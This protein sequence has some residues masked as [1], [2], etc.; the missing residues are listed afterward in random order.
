[1]SPRPSARYLILGRT[2]NGKSSF[3][4]SVFGDHVAQTHAFEA[5]TSIVEHYALNT[6]LGD[7]TLIDTPGFA[8]GEDFDDD[9]RRA[10][11][12]SKHVRLE[13]V[14]VVLYVTRLDEHRLGAD[15]RRAIRAITKR[16]GQALWRKAWL[17]FTFAANVERERRD[18]QVQERR[19]RLSSAIREAIVEFDAPVT[20]GEFQR[21]WLVDNMAV[22]WCDDGVP[23]TTVLA[24]N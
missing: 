19:K 23:L 10:K 20:F 17:I 6:P 18:E 16:F 13:E 12:I 24:P 11:T 21:C 8:E 2:G 22:D 4:N 9:R 7:I 5:C 1:L 14:E 15:E 3:I